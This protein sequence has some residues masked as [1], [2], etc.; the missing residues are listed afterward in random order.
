MAFKKP[1]VQPK[2]ADLKGVLSQTQ[3]DNTSYQLLQTLIERLIQYQ[4]VIQEELDNKTSSDLAQGPKGEKGEPGDPG[5]P[6]GPMGPAGPTGPTGA[7]GATGPSGPKG[8]TGA[9]G[10][11]GN[12]GPEGA[13]STVP[14]PVGP[15]GPIGL[16]GP[17]GP[18]GDPSTV[19]GPE[20]PQGDV[21]PQGP[22]GI[23]GP[24]GPAGVIGPHQ[25]THQLGGT[26]PL[27][28]NAWTNQP[29]T[30]IHRQT[31]DGNP[32]AQYAQLE[33]R[34]TGAPA[35]ILNDAGQVANERKARLIYLAKV[36]KLDFVTDD[37]SANVGSGIT[38]DRNGS[39]ATGGNIS[40]S[41]INANGISVATV[42]NNTGLASGTYQPATTNLNN[43]S[44]AAF[45]PAWYI[46][47]GNIVMVTAFG[48]LQSLSAG[49]ASHFYFSLP[50]PSNTPAGA[51][52][53]GTMHGYVGR[54]VGFISDGTA[55]G[56]VLVQYLASY[57]AGAQGMSVNFSYRIV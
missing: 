40:A 33:L 56:Y 1:K 8:D 36:L 9:Q 27:Q 29:N 5:G 14:G 12:T 48:T 3:L 22:Q 19:P 6:P 20:G 16:T 41:N 50:F 55:Y 46:R 35:L 17:Q 37:E 23:Q 31:I 43:I 28:N 15:Q 4:D 11:I 7:T 53:A 54:E 24:Q 25:A 2:F 44:V 52:A 10:P 51:V 38:L 13:A 39:F 26:D 32:Y 57:V 21:G 42:N 47:V 18:E 45:Y 49:T 30:F 34:A